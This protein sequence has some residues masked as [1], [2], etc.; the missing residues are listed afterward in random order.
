MDNDRATFFGFN[1]IGERDRVGLCHIA[2][3]DQDAIAIDE[4]LRE[5]RS[6]A[7]AIGGTQTGYCR[8]VSYAG[9]VLDGEDA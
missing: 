4:V 9:L 5:G 8:T 1:D 2:S 6:A 7:T 3:H